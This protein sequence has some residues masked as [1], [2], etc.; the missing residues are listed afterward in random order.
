MK[1]E[2]LLSFLCG[3]VLPL[4]VVLA[5]GRLPPGQP[6][7][8][9]TESVQETEASE[10]PSDGTE[11]PRLTD[12]AFAVE[13]LDD[14]GQTV[15]MDLE[16]YLLGVV[17]AEMPADFEPEAL[18]AQA[19]VA[20]TYTCRR[21]GQGRHDPAAV[22]TDPGCCQAFR[23]KEEYLEAGGKED[24]VQKVLRAVQETAGEVLTY[25]GALIDAT[26]FSCS[27]G[28]TEDAVEV[29]GQDVPY[30]R[31]VESPGEETAPR[32]R[33]EKSF[34]PE[35][36]RQLTGVEG[37]GAPQGWFG[38]P[39]RTDGGGVDRMEIC[40]KTFTGPELRRLLGLQIGRAH[41]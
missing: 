34:S 18:K 41:V 11:A 3:T 2:L 6:R 5:A 10:P 30:L 24:S 12:A 15:Q 26:Y 23:S 35:Q 8:A 22:C 17:L 4:A 37:G 13:V 31:A 1:K 16:G 40:G 38:A 28:F 39:A 25:E 27:G 21:M 36:F 14:S 9:E 32:F 29:W 20:R 7:P 33:E 19:V